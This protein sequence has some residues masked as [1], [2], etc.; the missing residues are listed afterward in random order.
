MGFVSR[1]SSRFRS[2]DARPLCRA[3]P[4]QVSSRLPTFLPHACRGPASSSDGCAFILR[5]PSHP[6]RFGISVLSAE[7]GQLSQVE[8]RVSTRRTCSGVAGSG[9]GTTLLHF[10]LR[11]EA[12]E[13]LL[14]CRC[15][16][17][18]LRSRELLLS[19]LTHHTNVCKDL[20]G[21]R[22]ACPW[23]VSSMKILNLFKGLWIAHA[24]ASDASL[25]DGFSPSM[26]LWERKACFPKFQ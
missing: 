2:A 1:A 18:L 20:A 13:D 10:S 9:G 26:A 7:Q 15:L 22:S 16:L 24:H 21:A 19:P 14:S 8:R 6:R 4:Q 5:L 23:R 11:G 12:R 3:P 25:P 17:W